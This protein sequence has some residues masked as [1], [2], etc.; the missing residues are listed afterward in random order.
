MMPVACAGCAIAGALFGRSACAGVLCLRRS[1]I[2]TVLQVP[3][4]LS[5]SVLALALYACLCLLQ[6]SVPASYCIS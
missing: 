3:L 4:P 1:F 5:V 2:N 6:V